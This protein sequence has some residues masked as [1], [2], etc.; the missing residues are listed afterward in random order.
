MVCLCRKQA[1]KYFTAVYEKVITGGTSEMNQKGMDL[2]LTIRTLREEKG[3]TRV[4]L[5]E[6]AGISES[7]LKKIE[8]G[9][10]RPGIDTYQKI[11]GILGEDMIAENEGDTIRGNCA[12]RMRE[13]LM[14]STE[15]QALFMTGLL[16]YVAQNI[17]LVL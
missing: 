5:S 13:I 1:G 17:G 7:H 6:A 14:G 12:D 10:R 16:E 9:S 11:I 2:G 3:L 15:E 8:A 4:E